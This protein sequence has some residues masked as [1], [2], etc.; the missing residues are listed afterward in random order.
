L[1]KGPATQRLPAAVVCSRALDLM[2]L[3]EWAA[4]E[5]LL[6]AAQVRHPGDFWLNHHL[7]MALL[8]Q[9]PARAEEAV[10][11]FRAALALQSDSS[12][13]HQI[14]AV[15]LKEKGDLEGAMRC[16]QVALDLDP[17]DAIAH[18]NLGNTLG[19]T[20]KVDEA[21]AC[22]KRALA[23]DPMISEAHTGLGIMLESKGMRDEAITE[24]RE[25]VRV[26]G[27]DF[28]AHY[29]LGNALRVQGKLG[30]AEV[31]YRKA[32]ELEPEFAL[33]HCNLGQMLVLKG[34]FGEALPFLRRGDELGRRDPKWPYPSPQWVR[35]CERL[36]KLERQLS[37]VLSGKQRPA[38]AAERIALAEVC[39]FK[40]LF[41]QATRFCEEALAEQPNLASDV[42]QH[43]GSN[44]ARAAALAGAGQGKDA[45]QTDDR[46]RSRLRQQALKWLQ[47]DLVAYRQMLEKDADKTH[48]LIVQQLQLWQAASDFTG[49]RG[50]ALAKLSAAECRA[51]QQLWADVA[52]L[53]A[54]AQTQAAAGK[55]RIGK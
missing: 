29:N 7:G 5:R 51:W 24:H 44:A 11:Y 54:R 12:A 3:K 49:V 6:Q 42:G 52:D 38:D 27:R 14:L 20:G 34:Q 21:I 25:A 15:A 31:A 23:I 16:C 10:G 50:E 36:A 33:A 48:P 9:G 40:R 13:I 22:F 43:H 30:K 17:R 41:W 53:L 2:S 45:I 37:V 47:S 26:N 28:N 46:E 35:Q 19:T 39:Y 8:E 18:T 32:I 1:A 55:R 4:A